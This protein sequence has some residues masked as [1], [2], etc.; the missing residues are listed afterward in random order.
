M[1]EIYD[2]PLSYNLTKRYVVFTFK[3]FYSEFIVVGREN[4]P[5]EGPVIFAPNHNNAL[6][7]ALVILS[8]VRHNLPVV[9]L[10]RSDIFKDGFVRS[11]LRFS[12][13]MPAF[14]MRD[15]AENLGRNAD[16]F[17]KCIEALHHKKAL[18]I[19]P[20]GNQELELN[21]R[22]LVKGIFRIAFAAQQTMPD[23]LKPGV[24]IVPVGLDYGDIVKFGKP[25]I[26]SVG[27]PI[28][29]SEY[30]EKYSDN[31][32]IA[33]NL[34]RSRLF[35]DLSNLTLNLATKDYY[36]CFET[37]VKVWEKPSLD[38]YHL[39]DNTVY[40]FRA[41][42]LAAKQLVKL[43]KTDPEAIKQLNELSARYSQLLSTTKLTDKV[44]ER[45]QKSVFSLLFSSFILLINFPFYVFGLILNFLPF[46]T[47]VLVRKY[48]FKAK[49]IGFFSSLQYGIG[50]LS[51]PFFYFIQALL[52]GWLT[53]FSWWT[54][55]LFFFLQY[56]MGKLAFF[57]HSSQKKFAGWLRYRIHHNSSTVVELTSLRRQIVSV[58]FD[59]LR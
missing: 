24:K 40:R 19:M 25:V 53:P 21:I 47:P 18:G 14:R 35:D 39:P 43:E 59:H 8:I 16:V 4:I 28:E 32:V 9:F 2:F 57:W 48:V 20:E 26:V 17:E 36:S 22:P 10:A 13:I 51:F 30:M 15:G 56:P 31:Q 52:F 34:I 23:P 41:R 49:F 27:K 5:S 12:K 58:F 7:D 50:L 33:T 45:K 54:A 42:Q 37:V 38:Y 44:L 55:V 3:R 1:S 6:M 46:F 29:V 11:A